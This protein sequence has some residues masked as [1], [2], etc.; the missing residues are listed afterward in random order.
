MNH[1]SLPG[2]RVRTLTLL[3]PLEGFLLALIGSAES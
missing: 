1:Q 2:T 3:I